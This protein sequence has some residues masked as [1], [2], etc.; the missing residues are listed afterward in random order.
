MIKKKDL[1]D[2]LKKEGISLGKGTVRY[3]EIEGLIPSSISRGL[4]RGKGKVAF[5][6]EIVVDIV[7]DLKRLQSQGMSL[8]IIKSELIRK[9]REW[10]YQEDIR[11]LMSLKF[12]NKDLLETYCRTWGISQN[13]IDVKVSFPNSQTNKYANE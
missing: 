10:Y 7:K 11:K 12:Y 4:G 13:N 6:P 9:Y 1:I 3:Y 8:R 5:Y 2:L